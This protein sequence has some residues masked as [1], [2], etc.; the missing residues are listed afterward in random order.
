MP[1]SAP[2]HLFVFGPGFTAQP[3]IRV[4][5]AAGWTVTATCR[6]PETAVMLKD[7]GAVPVQFDD[8]GTASFAGVSHCLQS[9]AP[10]NGTR[11]GA[12]HGEMDGDPVLALY[13]DM[14]SA[15]TDLRWIGYLS[16]TNVYGDHGGNWVDEDTPTAPTL[17]RGRRRVVAEAQW[18]E[19]GRTIQQNVGPDLSISVD[20]FRLAGIYGPGRS[21][22]DSL[23]AGTARRVIKPGHVFSRIHVDDIAAV[24]WAAMTR[25]ASA[26]DQ[27]RDL[28]GHDQL[29]VQGRGLGGAIYNLADRLPAPPQDVISHAAALLGVDP[30]AAIDFADAEM[31]PMARSFYAES[32]RVRA[33]RIHDRLGVGLAYPTYR[34]GLKAIMDGYS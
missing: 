32:K 34:E 5:L 28:G 22:I 1:H 26:E 31:S 8:V 15:S 12:P 6:R 19:L 17:D 24:L 25:A 3:L 30:P 7:M 18:L 29:C 10:K 23:K 13:H 9:I 11:D 33:T 14:L 4:A 16:S 27:M 2:H 20:I 21:A